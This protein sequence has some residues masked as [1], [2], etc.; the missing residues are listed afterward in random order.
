MADARIVHELACCESVFWDKLFFND[1]FNR[2]L[3][4]GELHFS[5][6]RV[7][8]T[9]DTNADLVEQ[10]VEATP[11]IGDLPGPLRA[12]I[13][14]GLS[15]HEVGR[16]DRKRRRYTVQAKSKPLGDKLLVD[17]ELF[18]EAIDETRC[19]RIF[20]VR[21]TAKIFGI[22]GMLEKRLLAD[23][24]Q[25]YATSARFIDQYVKTLT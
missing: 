19:R 25:N 9:G 3:F 6:W 18:T 11:P 16:C 7:L 23:L 4:L 12:L 14:E 22:G 20:A 24:E 8:R 5:G 2:C 10:E 15:Y 17:G 1:E 13:G 21:V